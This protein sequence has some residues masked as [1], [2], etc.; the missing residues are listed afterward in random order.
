MYTKEQLKKFAEEYKNGLS[1]SEVAIKYHTTPTIV[2]KAL[3]YFGVKPR[4][5]VTAVI[6]RKRTYIYINKEAVN[7]KW[8]D[9]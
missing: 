1:L 3:L 6:K 5:P 9:E 4:D 7:M 2:R 8:E